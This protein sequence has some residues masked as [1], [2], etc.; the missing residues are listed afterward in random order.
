MKMEN[1]F[2]DKNLDIQEEKEMHNVLINK[3]MIK[4]ILLIHV[5]VLMKIGNVIMVFI[6]KLMVVLVYL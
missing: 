6:E 3:I 1:V 5:N 2:L 4:F